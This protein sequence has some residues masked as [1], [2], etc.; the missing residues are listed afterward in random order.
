MLT[1][2]YGDGRKVPFGV[3]VWETQT[4]SHSWFE[5]GD[6]PNLTFRQRVARQL[7]RAA[8]QRFLSTLIG[9]LATRRLPRRIETMLLRLYAN[10]YSVNSAE[11]ECAIS[12]YDTVQEFFTRRLRL[13]ARPISTE[14]DCVVSPCDGRVCEAGLAT[15]GKLLEAKGSLFTLRN[16]LADDALADRLTGGAYLAV[17]LSPRDYHRVHSPVNGQIV[18]WRHIPGSLFPVGS[19]SVEREPGLFAKNERLVTILESEAGLC[20]VVMIAAVGV[21]NITTSYDPDVATHGAGFAKNAMRHKQFPHPI[22][23]GRGEELGIFNLGSTTIT[24]FEP[25]RVELTGLVS[26]AEIRMGSP[27]GRMMSL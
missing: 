6:M 5:T 27:V 8:P 2:T 24:V 12:D 7:W 10:I 16:L 21:G 14:K 15:S 26:D 18:S 9:W 3:L 25:G 17:Y 4:S 23:I 22:P 19:G 13:Q 11:A 20:A 1:G